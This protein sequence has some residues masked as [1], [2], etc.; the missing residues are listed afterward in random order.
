MAPAPGDEHA[1]LEAAVADAE[2]EVRAGRWLDALARYRDILRTRLDR[3]GS[4][5]GTAPQLTAADAI[6]VE[7]LAD[8]SIVTG[9]PAQAAKL[10][11]GLAATFRQADNRFAADLI[12]LKLLHIAISGGD[13]PGIE[14][15]LAGMAG[16]IGDFNQIA[17]DSSGIAEFEDA[18]QWPR[19]DPADRALFFAHF[20]LEAGRLFAWLGHFSD[21]DAALR[22]SLHHA[23]GIESATFRS[24]AES[25][26]LELDAAALACGDLPPAREHLAALGDDSSASHLGHEVRYRELTAQAALL[27]GDFGQAEQSLI[28]A[29]AICIRHRLTA[30]S[31]TAALN[32]VHVLVLVNRTVEA[33]GLLREAEAAAASLEDASLAMRV[34]GLAAFVAARRRSGC[35]GVP[36]APSN[37]ELWGMADPSDPTEDREEGSFELGYAGGTSLFD[38]LADYTLGFYHL[39]ERNQLK[40]AGAWLAQMNAVFGS[41]DSPLIAL[42]V[43]LLEGMLAY[44]TRDY[45]AATA[46]LDRLR[47]EFRRRGLRHDWWQ[48]NCFR[49]WTQAR[50]GEDGASRAELLAETQ[51]L[52]AAMG[53]GLPPEKRTLF[54][55]NKWSEEEAH[56]A[57]RI[58]AMAAADKAAR[59]QRWPRRW[60]SRWRV[61]ASLDA[62]VASLDER[63]MALV[64]PSG[65]ATRKAWWHRLLFH[66]RACLTVSFGIF[67]DR[68]LVVREGFLRFDFAV[69]PVTRLRVRELVRGWHE[70]VAAGPAQTPDALRN[71]AELSAHLGFAKLIGTTRK[72]R[73]LR[74]VPDDALH[75]FPFAALRLSGRFLVENVAVICDATH[76]WHSG[77]SRNSPS[78]TALIAAMSLP[79]GRL[80]ALPGVHREAAS[81]ARRFAAGGFMLKELIDGEATPAA[82][83]S[84]LPLARV[85]HVACHGIFARDDLRGTGLIFAPGL[86]DGLLS[87]MDLAAMPLE[88][89]DHITLTSC[90]S[91]DNYI[92]P[93][94]H[95]VSLPQ[96]LRRAGARSVV[97]SLWPVDDETAAAFHEY[98]YGQCLHHGPA[99][100]LRRTQL[101][102]IRGEIQL[103]GSTA[104]DPFHWAGFAL[105]GGAGS[106]RAILGVRTRR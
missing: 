12:A 58:D 47:G 3:F 20:F 57:A 31:A 54:E 23:G 84:A 77:A 32:L 39:L 66:P 37:S 61:L 6:I 44:Y 74:L 15:T 1:S 96:I 83:R 9:H 16:T 71:A 56:L 2:A 72:L 53:A 85:A 100:A 26:R 97:A 11:K 18:C 45:P 13:R 69:M 89:L 4:R 5:P 101:A 105:Y 46:L 65:P 43:A 75:G 7:R 78:R 90:W 88:S 48:V 82:I 21:A 67:P 41:G 60:L 94:R 22:R 81:V 42:R 35:A 40:E 55:L 91:A 34:R 8:I 63:R 102:C 29:R 95:L 62:L 25:A 68:V 30:A 92:L 51:G 52:L 70:A 14:S 28:A 98:F 93:G 80:P 17:F 73:E 86:P 64:R 19:A 10:F 49:L 50:L 106:R 79:C 104:D 87:L 76:V 38:R 27:A 33:E 103:G 24:L 99:E 59:A 36:V